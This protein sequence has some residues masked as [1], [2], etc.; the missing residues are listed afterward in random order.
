MGSRMPSWIY[1]QLSPK[2][3]AAPLESVPNAWR[4]LCTHK[5][6]RTR[7]SGTL[8]YLS[9]Q[10]WKILE[11]SYSGLPLALF[12]PVLLYFLFLGSVRFVCRPGP[13]RDSKYRPC[14]LHLF[15]S[16]LG[17]AGH[18]QWPD[19]PV[20]RWLSERTSEHQGNSCRYG[21]SWGSPF[22]CDFR[23]CSQDP[24]PI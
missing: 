18:I 15:K 24:G 5:G 2:P 3:G 17:G 16:I 7:F 8:N 20:C 13:R 12:F 21:L 6:R 14:T 19:G 9:F 10:V 22:S 1:L 23:Q 11:E 4:A